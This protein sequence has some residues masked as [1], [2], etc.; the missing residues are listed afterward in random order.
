VK[1]EKKQKEGRA[2][3][4]ISAKAAI[5]SIY[6]TAIFSQEVRTEVEVLNFRIISQRAHCAKKESETV[7]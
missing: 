6:Q 4:A 1:K 5:F 7:H 2:G 3:A